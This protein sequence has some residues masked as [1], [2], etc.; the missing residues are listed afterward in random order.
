MAAPEGVPSPQ[1]DL[2]DNGAV[3]I[4]K[5]AQQSPRLFLADLALLA[6]TC[7]CLFQVYRK[8]RAVEE[9]WLEELRATSESKFGPQIAAHVGNWLFRRVQHD[10]CNPTECGTSNAITWGALQPQA[11][12]PLNDPQE[13]WSRTF[14]LEPSAV[15]LRGDRAPSMEMWRLCDHHDNRRVTFR[16]KDSPVLIFAYRH[17]GGLCIWMDDWSPTHVST[18]VGFVHRILEAEALLTET[19]EQGDGEQAE[20][21]DLFLNLPRSVPRGDTRRCNAAV[22]GGGEVQRAISALLMRHWPRWKIIIK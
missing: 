8:A 5:T 9:A 3:E 17:G 13:P 11:P 2:E 22:E 1:A 7:K 6:L 12:G 20:R 19:D 4:A 18:C 15:G 16:E 10:A 14:N 21:R